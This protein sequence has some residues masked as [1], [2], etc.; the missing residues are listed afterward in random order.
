MGCGKGVSLSCELVAERDFLGEFDSGAAPVFKGE[1]CQL[2]SLLFLFSC[3]LG[4]SSECVGVFGGG[5]GICSDIKVQ[6]GG[7]LCLRVHLLK[8]VWGMKN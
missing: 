1:F 7:F 4:K 8:W 5:F 3:V 2:P 6:M